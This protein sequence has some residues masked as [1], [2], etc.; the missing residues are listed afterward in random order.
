MDET[1]T[2]PKGSNNQEEKASLLARLKS[3]SD[4]AMLMFLGAVLG[5]LIMGSA[6][7]EGAVVLGIAW[8]NGFDMEFP[9]NWS[10]PVGSDINEAVRW[11]TR[12][13]EWL[14]D[15]MAYSIIMLIVYIKKGLT[16]VP[17]PA[18]ILGISL[19][20]YRMLGYKFGIF[21]LISLLLLAA[22]GM[23]EK[24]METLAMIGTSV[25]I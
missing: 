8:G 6:V 13:G 3:P 24:A 22:F 23:W 11:T 14:F 18:A 10:R 4:L 9:I 20:S 17:W 2:Q 15:N 21:T 25:I 12:E 16:W 5:C 1:R 19:L 7:E